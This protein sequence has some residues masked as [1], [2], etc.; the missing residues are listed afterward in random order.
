MVFW[1]SD[2]IPTPGIQFVS[3]NLFDNI[4]LITH[5]PLVKDWSNNVITIEKINNVSSLKMSK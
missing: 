2:I 3:E 4:F 1:Y 5:N